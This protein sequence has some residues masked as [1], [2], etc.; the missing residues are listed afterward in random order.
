MKVVVSALLL[1]FSAFWYA[2]V[3]YSVTDLVLVPL[4][5]AFAFVVYR[6]ANRPSQEISSSVTTNTP[7]KEPQKS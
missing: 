7:G 1:S 4:F 3:F 6:V 2:E 5:A